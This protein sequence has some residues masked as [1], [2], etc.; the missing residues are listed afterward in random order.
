MTEQEHVTL[1]AV[2]PCCSATIPPHVGRYN[3]KPCRGER[4]HDLT[5]PVGKLWISVEKQDTRSAR[6]L[7]P[8]FQH[9]KSKPVDIADVAR[10]NPCRERERWKA[11]RIGLNN[12]SMRK[13]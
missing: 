9:V 3:M 2:V 1:I 11:R 4:Q 8:G 5:P 7:K 12:C 6:A 10:A 13:L